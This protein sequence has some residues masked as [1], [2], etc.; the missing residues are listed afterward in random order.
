MAFRN[1]GKVETSYISTRRSSSNR[2][3]AR[4]FVTHPIV[5]VGRYL[6]H[7]SYEGAISNKIPQ[8]INLDRLIFKLEIVE[9][10]AA[11]PPTNKSIFTDDK[12]NSVVI[13]L[14]KRPKR[15]DPPDIHVMAFILA[16]P[17]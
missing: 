14:S 8:N 16:I 6:S 5:L 4:D 10:L 13:P 11:S 3:W 1:V 17:G 2:D 9:A 15:Y 12:V 7:R